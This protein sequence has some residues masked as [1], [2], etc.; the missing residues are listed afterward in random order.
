MIGENNVSGRVENNFKE[1]ASALGVKR[2][3]MEYGGVDSRVLTTSSPL[4]TIY[5]F[6]FSKIQIIKY[7]ICLKEKVNDGIHKKKEN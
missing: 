6:V 7:E 3:D 5:V 4:T 1:I 2:T